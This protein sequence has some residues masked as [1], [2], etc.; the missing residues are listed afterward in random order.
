MPYSSFD[1]PTAHFQVAPYTGNGDSADDTNAITNTGNSAMK[2]DFTWFKRRDY[3]NQHLLFDSTR[4]VTKYITSDRNDAEGTQADRLVSFDTDG[5][6]VKSSSGAINAENEPFI[7]WQWK[8]N[9]GTTSTNNDGATAST[10]QANTDA[11]FSIV[12]WTGTGSATTLG[13]GLGVAPAMLIVKNRT[14]SVDWAVYHKDLTD[15]GYVLALN[16]TDAQ[17]DS[18][19]NRWNHTDPTSSVFSVGAGQQTN[20]NTNSMICYAFANIKGFSNMGSY[21]G[22][23][24]S[25]G[26][27]LYCSFRPAFVMIKKWTATGPW[28]IF[29]DRRGT[30]SGTVGFN[31]DYLPTIQANAVTAEFSNVLQSIDI[32]SNGFKIRTNQ[33]DINQ[34]GQK[35]IYMAFAK[36]PFV[37]SGGVPTVAF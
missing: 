28:N 31:T 27:M 18:G 9:G 14:T 7:C 13:H 19:T 11:G 20:Q 32:L 17:A 22:N 1:D 33:A 26:M 10:V 21:I 36:H 30:E 16:S 15:A 12:T 25:N 6:T 2:P 5:F 3:D 37:T 34:V 35:Y 29:D 23:Q 8:A 4:G 24:D